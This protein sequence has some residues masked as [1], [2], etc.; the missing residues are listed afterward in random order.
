MR[1]LMMGVRALMAF[2]AMLATAQAENQP[3]SPPTASHPVNTQTV[4]QT[5]GRSRA[6]LRPSQH[7]PG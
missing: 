1:Q 6:V 5:V 7:A 3:P 2:G 4:S